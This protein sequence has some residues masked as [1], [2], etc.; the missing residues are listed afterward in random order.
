MSFTDTEINRNAP[1]K[2][3]SLKRKPKY[4]TQDKIL[5]DLNNNVI[6][7]LNKIL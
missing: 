3:G 7:E 2:P 1:R 5:N 4:T 6:T